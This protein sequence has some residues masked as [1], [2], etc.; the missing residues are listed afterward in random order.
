MKSEGQLM[1]RHL[2]LHS[3]KV[4]GVVDFVCAA[5]ASPSPTGYLGSVICAAIFNRRS[6]HADIFSMLYD[7][8]SELD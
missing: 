3:A 8:I 6:R 5:V 7:L 4:A 2:A 1:S